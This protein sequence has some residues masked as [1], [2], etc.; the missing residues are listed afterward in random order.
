MD[1]MATTT[2]YDG[3]GK[4]LVG[5]RRLSRASDASSSPSKQRDQVL[6]AVDAVG[7]HI[8]AWADDWEVSGATDPR[9]R[10]GLG[11]WLRGEQGPYDGIAGAAV[12]RIGR[13]VRDVLNT[14]DAIREAGQTLITADHPGV[15]ELTDP[16]QENE[17]TFK[18]MG[19]QMEHRAIRTRNREHT[20]R[21][22]REGR[23][24]QRPS[25]GYRFVRLVPTGKVDHVAID[26]VAAEIIRDVAKRILADD[27]EGVITVATEAARLTRA[28]VPSP[29]DRRAQLYG[30]PLAGSPWTAKTVR[31]ILRS[32]AALG[33]LMHQGKPVIGPDGHPVRIAEPLWDHPTHV[34]LLKATDPKRAGSRA[35]KSARM[36]SRLAYCGTCGARLYVAGGTGDRAAY[37]CKGRVLGLPA[38][39]HCKPAPIMLVTHLDAY[40]AAWFLAEYGDGEIM[41][42]VYDPG[43]GHAARIGELETDRA[44][45]RADR[46][47][48]LYDDPDDAE[49][50]RTEYQRM[51]REIAEL[52]RLPDRPAGMRNVPTGRTVADEWDAAADDA[53]RRGLLE[54][55]GVRVTLNT[56]TAEQRVT[57]MGVDVWEDA[58]D[59]D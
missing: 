39:A 36:L 38:S 19:A 12:D 43:T 22:R 30:R 31:G 8:I 3:C 41:D 16:N 50:F 45:L 52:K 18:A 4:C 49:W 25:Y 23:V 21:A 46:Q 44:R 9:T 15:W 6:S 20:Q 40:V 28:G 55:F 33:Y 53:G 56:R 35:Q 26:D 51:G 34:A 29:G 54:A 47:A 2:P 32:E 5:V 13:N 48:G 11:P 57:V 24:K 37:G 1:D 59:A 7:G 17:L 42:R 27:G 58:A 10:P 14:A